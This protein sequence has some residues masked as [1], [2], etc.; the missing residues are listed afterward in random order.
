MKEYYGL[1]N[2]LDENLKRV[3]IQLN[4]F[5]YYGGTLLHGATY[6]NFVGYAELL[7]KDGFDPNM[8]DRSDKNRTPV[9][10]AQD[11]DNGFLMK[12]LFNEYCENE[13]DNDSKECKE[14]EEATMSLGSFSLRYDVCVLY[15]F[16]CIFFFVCLLRQV[17]QRV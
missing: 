14:Y 4:R 8:K 12:S 17:P 9:S 11:I 13:Y 7:L 5:N 2:A 3:N 10:I 16:F 1:K 6:C 15:M